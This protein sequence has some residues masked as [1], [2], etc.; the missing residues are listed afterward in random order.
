MASTISRDKAVRMAGL[1]SSHS[2]ASTRTGHQPGS[3]CTH[4]WV[5]GIEQRP[6]KNLPG[7]HY[8]RY[9]SFGFHGNFSRGILPRTRGRADC[10]QLVYR[11]HAVTK[12]KYVIQVQNS[13]GGQCGHI[14]V[15][16]MEQGAIAKIWLPACE[17]ILM[18]QILCWS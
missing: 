7:R 14:R 16:Q 18:R 9:R 15:D 10:E 6:E 2:N 1:R 8:N 12:S 5:F 17:R 3:F 4:V 13:I 11:V